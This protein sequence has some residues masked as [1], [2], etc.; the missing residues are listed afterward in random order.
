MATTT[1]RL[2]LVKQ[3]VGENPGTWGTVL[4]GGLQAA[5]DRLFLTGAANPNVNTQADYIFQRY[6]DSVGD[7]WFTAQ[8][9]AGPP[10]TWLLGNILN[11]RLDTTNSFADK[12]TFED[13]IILENNIPVQSI[14]TGA[15][16]RNILAL[17]GS[18]IVQVGTASLNTNIASLVEIT[19]TI[20]NPADP[21]KQIWHEGLTDEVVDATQHG[22]G[23]GTGSFFQSANLP[24]TPTVSSAVAHGLG[25][26]PT[27]FTASLVCI[28]G[29][30]GY[31]PP[32]EIPL[33]TSVRE[34]AAAGVPGIRL[35]A[36]ATSVFRG[37][38]T[39]GFKIMEAGTFTYFTPLN[40]SYQMILR[41][42][43]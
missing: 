37:I 30:N 3:D 21:P 29:S 40:V 4:N 42:W 15:Q 38:A 43:A 14:T 26:V 6:Y 23:L 16:T 28:L 19:A 34:V 39:P 27:L 24:I 25:V 10:S 7:N 12:I 8:D 35:F 22:L 41:A 5:D 2:A 17:N 11:A 13:N 36:D 9:T 31:A 18:D 1:S 33:S 32:D 20:G